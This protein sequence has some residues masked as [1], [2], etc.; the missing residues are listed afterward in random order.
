MGRNKMQSVAIP[1]EDIAEVSITN[2]CSILQHS[3]EHR[4][5]IAGGATDDL[6]NLGRGR[7]LI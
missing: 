5:Q 4:L 1:T 7:L 2:P 6:K 3:C